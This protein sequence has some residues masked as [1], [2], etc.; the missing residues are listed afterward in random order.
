[1]SLYYNNFKY[2]KKNSIDQGLI[3]A[4]FEPDDGFVD[5]FLSME[6]IQEDYYDGTKKFDYGARYNTT[7]V[8][9]ITVLKS[10]GSD[11]SLKDV[12]SLS[13]WLTGSRVNSWLDVGPSKDNIKYSFLGR[14]TN[15]QQRKIDGRIIGLLIEFTSISPWA[16]S[17]PQ[18]FE[19]DIGG[20]I[21]VIDGGV[22]IKLGENGSEFG[23]DN[24]GVLT[25]S[26]DIG[27]YFNITSDGVI[28]IDNQYK[29][30]INNES[31]DLYSYIYLDIDY[32]NKSGTYLS[33]KNITLNEE[34]LIKNI[35]K[36]E[37]ITMSS[38][39]FITSSIP[40]KL[41]GDD[42]NFVWPRLVP[43]NNNFIISSDGRGLVLFTY[44]YPMKVGDCAM[45]VSV[46]GGNIDCGEMASYETVKWENII[47]APTSIRGYGITDAYTMDEID[48]RLQEID[49]DIEWNEISNTPTTVAGY[50]IT[51]TYTTNDVYTK[52]EVDDKIGD[53]EISDGGTNNTN[54]D[55]EEFNSMLKDI[56]G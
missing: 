1:L 3:V 8:I 20:T 13:K 4:S 40:N 2:L 38:K 33:I 50:G 25:V 6:P 56:F 51:D 41:F 53:I 5:S 43:E 32:Q 49:V 15:L 11:F 39:Q 21:D 10:N 30:N 54:I 52:T 29:T 36:N 37:F 16:F 22:V 24:Q 45:D 7:A 12:R 48:N 17:N 46:Y 27:S 23:I 28:Y 26:S 19:C 18:S 42:F 47:G 34:T 55:E 31:D 44:R 35:S 9:N 14:V